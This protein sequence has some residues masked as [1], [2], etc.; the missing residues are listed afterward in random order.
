MIK[1]YVIRQF[2]EDKKHWYYNGYGMTPFSIRIN[3]SYLWMDETLARKKMVE[4]N[5][6]YED[7]E[8]IA[9][10]LQI[11]PIRAK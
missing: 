11:S 10:K 6:D 2:Q 5:D 3:D 7:L 8:I 1:R 9:V 4:L